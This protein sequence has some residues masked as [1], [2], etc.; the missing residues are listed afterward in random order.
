MTTMFQAYAEGCRITAE[1]PRAAAEAFF[2]SFPKKRR[3][4]IAEGT[5]DG[6]F[7]TVAYSLNSQG[8]KPQ[9]FRD[10]TKSHIASLPGKPA[11]VQPVT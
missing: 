11:A 9:S 10:V 3:C 2:K 6:H 7:F 8:Q 4:S 1:S 5:V